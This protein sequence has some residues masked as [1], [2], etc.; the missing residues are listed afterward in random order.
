MNAET[1][2]H[3]LLTTTTYLMT[4]YG[5][6]RG[7]DNLD[8]GSMAVAADIKQQLEKLIMH[9]AIQANTMARNAYEGLLCEWCNILAQ[10]QQT[11]YQTC[12][13]DKGLLVQLGW[14]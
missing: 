7:T 8:W 12:R 13:E 11:D 5:L 10:H 1:E 3:T 9:P 14:H 6:Q 2:L 4:R